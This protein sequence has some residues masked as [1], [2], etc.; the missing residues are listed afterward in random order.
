[1]QHPQSHNLNQPCYHAPRMRHSSAS[2]T[3]Q[4]P[5]I[6][7]ANPSALCRAS[8]LGLNFG[9][10]TR[11]LDLGSGKGAAA[12]HLASSFGCHVTCFNL[13][14]NQNSHNLAEARAA[15]VD[16]LVECVLG[17][18][19]SGLPADWTATFDLVWSQESLCHAND[20][21][22]VLA[23]ITRVLKPGGVAVFTDIMRTVRRLCDTP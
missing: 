8:S 17:N 14:S 5:A 9:V 19:N 20:Q 16:H 21:R 12:R 3:M 18:F 2:W 1:M 6:T 22:K 13:G 11:V 7:P 15:G 23:E 4:L 10:G